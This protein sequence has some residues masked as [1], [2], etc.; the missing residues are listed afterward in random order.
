MMIFKLVVFI[1]AIVAFAFF[2]G[3]NLDNKTDIWL[4]FKTYHDVPVFMNSLI[5]FAFGALCSLPLV[6]LVRYKR[7]SKD[8]PKVKKS[9]TVDKISES[10]ETKYIGKSKKLGKEGR[11]GIIAK[12]RGLN[13]KDDSFNES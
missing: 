4:F 6:L 7:E 12:I 3:F 8:E 11:E 1:I 9:K 5:S 2:A 10:A 13:N